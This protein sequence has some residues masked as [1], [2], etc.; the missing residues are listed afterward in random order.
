M[1]VIIFSHINL[2]KF[3]LNFF[4][5]MYQNVLIII[6]IYKYKYIDIKLFLKTDFI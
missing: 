4:E 2:I 5:Y 3:D 1:L 6:E